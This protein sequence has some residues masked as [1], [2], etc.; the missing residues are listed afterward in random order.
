[1]N[2]TFTIPDGKQ[3]VF[4]LGESARATF[5][6]RTYKTL[7][8]AIVAFVLIEVALF[9]TALP[10]KSLEFLAGGRWRWLLFLGGFMVL[11]SL[12]TR[13]AVS[14]RSQAAQL[15]ALV[16]YVLLQALIFM[17]LLVVAQHYADG[18]VIESAA[19]V[20]LAAFAG[21]TAI[22]FVTRK[23]FSF[24]RGIVMY[25][26]LVALIAIVAGVIFDFQLGVWFS[27]G[28]V[29]LAG[30]AI[31]YDTSNI[32]HRYPEDS[33]VAAALQ[34]FASVALMFWYVLMLFMSGR[35]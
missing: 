19:L 26:M 14:A 35:D 28:M 6:G 34:L 25:G 15:A 1:M 27:A 5:I 8:G 13:M 30:A 3:A 4:E 22:V 21:L 17:P 18:G 23:D 7:L 20:T 11:G 16:A 29:G 31:L 10:M 2:Q 9:Q 24:L 33:H 12:A 32:L